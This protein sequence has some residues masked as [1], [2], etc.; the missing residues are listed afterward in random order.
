MGFIPPNGKKF[1]LACDGLYAEAMQAVE[2]TERLTYGFALYQLT[3]SR[4]S[5]CAMHK[6]LERKFERHESVTCQREDNQYGHDHLHLTVLP[7]QFCQPV[8][9]RKDSGDGFR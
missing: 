8:G 3:N 1:C 9:F 6:G 4:Q 7:L 2:N 5:L